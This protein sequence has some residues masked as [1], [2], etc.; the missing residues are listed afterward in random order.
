M[1]C[2]DQRFC[3]LLG[4]AYDFY[5]RLAYIVRGL[6]VLVFVLIFKVSVVVVVQFFSIFV[7][8]ILFTA[9]V[10]SLFHSPFVFL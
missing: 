1:A 5:D 2:K 9:V 7:W 8:L 6:K 10:T 3:L 4:S